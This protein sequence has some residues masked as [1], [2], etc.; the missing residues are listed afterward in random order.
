MIPQGSTSM[1]SRYPQGVFFPISKARKVMRLGA[2]VALPRGVQ[3]LCHSWTAPLPSA[4]SRNDFRP[5]VL[6]YTSS[7][8]LGALDRLSQDG[9]ASPLAGSSSCN[10]EQRTHPNRVESP[11]HP[12]RDSFPQPSRSRS[13][14]QHHSEKCR[15]DAQWDRVG[16]VMW[17]RPG[18]AD[19]RRCKCLGGSTNRIE[20][21]G[22]Y[23]GQ[24]PQ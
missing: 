10:T 1:R 4:L 13:V 21:G 20:P 15:R 8:S 16:T 18:L 7:P 22:I 23:S 5:S 12:R 19:S 2:L 6:L 9:L 3:I 24:L 14:L 11:P 17:R